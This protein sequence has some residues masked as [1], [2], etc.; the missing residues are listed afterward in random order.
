MSNKTVAD[1]LAVPALTGIMAFFETKGTYE[2]GGKKPKVSIGGFE[3]STSIA[4]GIVCGVGSAS[5]E[6]IA[7]PIVSKVVSNP[8]VKNVAMSAF[9]PAYVGTLNS[10]TM[11]FMSNIPNVGF[12]EPFM[13]GAK[14]NVSANYTY[15]G[16]IKPLFM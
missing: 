1:K 13:I 3:V 16:I 8:K 5:S 15:N 14:S 9:E 11:Y 12:V 4:S 6:W 2:Q 7:E 10:G